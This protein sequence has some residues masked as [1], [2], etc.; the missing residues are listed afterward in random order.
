[1]KD[2]GS[3]NNIL[4]YKKLYHNHLG[5]FFINSQYNNKNTYVVPSVVEPEPDFFAG[6]GAREKEP[7]PACSYV[8]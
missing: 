3:E 4:E 5:I 7:A 1:M 6:A 8:I 2:T